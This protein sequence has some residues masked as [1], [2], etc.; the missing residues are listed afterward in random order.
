MINDMITLAI[1]MRQVAESIINTMVRHN[2]DFTVFTCPYCHKDITEEEI[3]FYPSMQSTNHESSCSY[4]AAK[5]ILERIGGK[6]GS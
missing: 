4:Y 3:G 2:K 6:A 5:R 1:D